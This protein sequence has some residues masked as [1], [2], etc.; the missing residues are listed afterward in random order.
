VAVAPTN[1]TFA[2][3]NILTGCG[4][5][6]GSAYTIGVRV[7]RGSAGTAAHAPRGGWLLHTSLHKLTRSSHAPPHLFP[8]HPHTHHPHP[9]CYSAADQRRVP[10]AGPRV[11]GRH[12]AGLAAV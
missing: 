12:H 6:P 8:C 10:V 5:A 3:C 4:G 1:T 9:R 11:D 2:T 7:R